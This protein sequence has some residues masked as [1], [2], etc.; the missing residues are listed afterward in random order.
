MTSI[1]ILTTAVALGFTAPLQQEPQQQ[2]QQQQQQAPPP[3][4]KP[5]APAATQ[6]DAKTVILTG[7]VIASANREDTFELVAA[8]ADP[9]KPVGT[10]G[11]APVWTVPAYRLLGGIVSAEHV[12]KT[13]EITGTIDPAGA[14]VAPDP[15][16][17]G[18]TTQRAGQDAAPIAQLHVQNAKVVSDTCTP[19]QAK[20]QNK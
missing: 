17:T 6:A 20:A 14:P 11:A 3:A 9:A 1:V 5:D 15:A 12:T 4:A 2:Q 8:E 7:C 18:D 19:K 10:S 16:K 13:V